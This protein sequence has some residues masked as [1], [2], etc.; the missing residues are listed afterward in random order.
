MKKYLWLSSILILLIAL[1][2]G[3]GQPSAK[4]STTSEV[5]S[6]PAP[7]TTKSGTAVI[8]EAYLTQRNEA[9]N[10]DSPAFWF[11]Q[12]Y[13][14][15]NWVI[16]TAKDGDALVV[17][18]AV[19]GSDVKRLGGSGKHDGQLSYPN[20]VAVIDNYCFVVERDNHR[21]QAFILPEFKPMGTF[22]SEDL[23]R[24]YGI[25]INKLG[26]NHFNIYI[27]DAY[28]ASN[29]DNVPLA[30]MDKRIKL[31]KVTVSGAK[32][33]TKLAKAFGDTSEKGAIRVT[34]SIWG[35]PENNVLLIAEEDRHF[36]N[37]KVYDLDGNFSGKT[38]GDGIFKYQAEGIVLYRTADGGGYWIT[39]DQAKTAPTVF[40]IFDRLSFKYLGS[41]SG[42]TTANTDGIAITQRAVGHF[43]SG[44]FFAVHD[45]GNIGAF[46]WKKVAE[47]L[48]LPVHVD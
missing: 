20:G 23:I 2:S 18:D 17:T 31:Y 26:D 24:P 3:C 40:H 34:E 39:T 11:G 44:M 5:N 28:E 16:A 15:G 14:S 4:Q 7:L 45:D 22:G 42:K 38:I 43:L 12:D 10:I 13:G 21:V 35:D 8:E 46:D 47:A 33:E 37:I 6:K 1:Y 27:T 25:Y 36:N 48:G 29:G 9:D 32:I 41:F 30:E 19:D